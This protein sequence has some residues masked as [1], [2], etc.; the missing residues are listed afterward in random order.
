MTSP[1]PDQLVAFVE[2]L[3][4]GQPW[5]VA[6][7]AAVAAVQSAYDTAAAIVFPDRISSAITADS[8]AMYTFLASKCPALA[9][10]DRMA[11]HHGSA[12]VEHPALALLLRSAEALADVGEAAALRA[13]PQH[14]SESHAQAVDRVSRAARRRY[15]LAIARQLAEHPGHELADAARAMVA[16]EGLAQRLAVAQAEHEARARAQAELEAQQKAEADRVARDADR[17]LVKD[18][19]AQRRRAPVLAPPDERAEFAYRV[20]LNKALAQRLRASELEDIR[21]SGGL[22]SVRQMI[23]S[24]ES[25]MGGF[26]QEQILGLDAA[27]DMNLDRARAG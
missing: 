7:E 2:N 13:H 11:T 18:I 6:F 20:A 3:P 22:Y 15:Q 27:L 4:S 12:L 26:S 9:Y 1:S 17:K 19:V 5:P 14:M 25:D 23:A 16:A 8:I 24:A 21:M 10:G